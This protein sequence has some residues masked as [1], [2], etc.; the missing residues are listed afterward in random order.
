MINLIVETIVSA[1]PD[2]KVEFIRDA[3][4]STEFN[5]VFE[6]KLDDKPVLLFNTAII[7]KID[8]PLG[9]AMSAIVNGLLA[10]IVQ[11]LPQPTP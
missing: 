11:H 7:N 8:K 4:K 1:F 10:Q 6:V 3:E 9:E 5:P 2:N